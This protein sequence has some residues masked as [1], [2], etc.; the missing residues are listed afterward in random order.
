[1]RLQSELLKKKDKQWG[2]DLMLFANA[3]FILEEH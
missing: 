1:M 2:S 3:H